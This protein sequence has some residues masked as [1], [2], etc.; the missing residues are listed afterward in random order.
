[1]AVVKFFLLGALKVIIWKFCFHLT[2]ENERNS[3]VERIGLESVDL[4]SNFSFPLTV[5]VR[6]GV[7]YF[8][9]SEF[10]LPYLVKW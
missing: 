4:D 10:L 5:C 8:S 6:F 3:L 9:L 7:S 1:M 2:K